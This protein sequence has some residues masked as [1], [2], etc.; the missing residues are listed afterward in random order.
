MEEIRTAQHEK[1][2]STRLFSDQI[3]SR[4][5]PVGENSKRRFLKGSS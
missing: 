4:A 2:T 5:V 1:G 3:L